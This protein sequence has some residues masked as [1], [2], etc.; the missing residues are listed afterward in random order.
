[1]TLQSIFSLLLLKLLKVAWFQMFMN[2]MI[3]KNNYWFAGRVAEKM[4]KTGD[5]RRSRWIYQHV[6][7]AYIVRDAASRST[8]TWYTKFL[9]EA[10]MHFEAVNIDHRFFMFQDT[11]IVILRCKKVV[12]FFFSSFFATVSFFLKKSRNVCYLAT[13]IRGSNL[14]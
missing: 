12:G 3:F 6:Y 13:R 2:E 9:W 5:D 11:Q 1:M 4:K 7:S 10:N 14:C 8:N